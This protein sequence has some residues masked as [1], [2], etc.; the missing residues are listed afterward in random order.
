MV[1]VHAYEFII[2]WNHNCSISVHILYT[3]CF[4][5]LHSVHQS[6]PVLLPVFHRIKV[7]SCSMYANR[8]E[9]IRTFGHSLPKRVLYQTELHP[10]N[11]AS[12]ISCRITLTG[13]REFPSLSHAGWI[14]DSLFSRRREHGCIP[15]RSVLIIAD[16]LSFS[17]SSICF[18]V[19]SDF[20]FSLSVCLYPCLP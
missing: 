5:V 9:R 15:V 14:S 11:N 4:S 10:V 3:Y 20:F 19:F 8:G 1:R 6:F 2:R 13:S 18:L 16:H 17:K 7:H 12:V